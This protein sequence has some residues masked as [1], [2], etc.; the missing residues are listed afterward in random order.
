[1]RA[2]IDGKTC[3]GERC[4]PLGIELAMS[5][6]R[7]QDP[8]LPNACLSDCAMR[9]LSVLGRTLLGMLLV[10]YRMPRTPD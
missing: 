10:V 9:N 7:D 3:E 8:T 2:L 1:M 4:C 5:R 6:D